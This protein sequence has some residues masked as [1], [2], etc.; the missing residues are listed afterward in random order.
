MEMSACRFEAGTGHEVTAS[1]TLDP[2]H[3]RASAEPRADQ[4]TTSHYRRL[5]RVA[6]G[7]SSIG[8]PV[9]YYPGGSPFGVSR[10]AFSNRPPIAGN[11]DHAS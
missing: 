7:V 5:G 3:P 11:S 4:P 1:E 8:S 6:T 2:G 10:V 9:V